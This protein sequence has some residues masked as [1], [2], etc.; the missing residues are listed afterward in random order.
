MSFFRY[1]PASGVPYREII[2]PV[3]M[4]TSTTFSQS[5][6]WNSSSG[7]VGNPLFSDANTD[8]AL[9]YGTNSTVANGIV[10]LSATSSGY[11][12]FDAEL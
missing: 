11:L 7:Y 4:R 5:G 10:Y 2:F 8:R 1:S 12:K 6:T 9:L 3:K